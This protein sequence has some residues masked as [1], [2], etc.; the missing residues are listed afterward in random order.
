MKATWEMID[1]CWCRVTVCAGL[2]S[3]GFSGCMSTEAFFSSKNAQ[4][5]AF[6]QMFKQKTHTSLRCWHLKN[7]ELPLKNAQPQEKKQTKKNGSVDLRPHSGW[8][9]WHIEFRKMRKCL[10]LISVW[11]CTF[12]KY[13]N[14][15]V[16]HFT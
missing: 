14:N 8:A 5:W 9:T 16:L 2:W 10:P 1:D 3:S 11:E 15:S 13:L 6:L 12:I 4:L 7:A